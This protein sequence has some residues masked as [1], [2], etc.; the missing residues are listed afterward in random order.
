[1]ELSGAKRSENYLSGRIYMWT[2]PH[3]GESTER[4]DRSDGTPG[5]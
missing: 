5:Y 2:V 3:A 1:M 4:F